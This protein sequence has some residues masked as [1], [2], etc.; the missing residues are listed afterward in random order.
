MFYMIMNGLVMLTRSGVN[1]EL[2]YS[3]SK[4]YVNGI[5]KFDALLSGRADEV[6]DGRVKIP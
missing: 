5:V 2:L 1:V 6:I 4:M 3:L